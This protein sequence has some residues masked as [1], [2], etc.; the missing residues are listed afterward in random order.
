[1]GVLIH[2]AFQSGLRASRLLLSDYQP[3]FFLKLLYMYN[4]YPRFLGWTD[5][6]LHQRESSYN[7]TH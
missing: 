7:E 4:G 6:G 3:G 2:I 1:M 5:L